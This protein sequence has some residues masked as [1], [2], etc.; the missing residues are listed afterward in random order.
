[1][2]RKQATISVQEEFAGKSLPPGLEDSLP[3]DLQDMFDNVRSGVRRSA[4]AYINLCNILERLAKRNEGIAV[5][6]ARFSSM[7]QTLTEASADPSSK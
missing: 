6:Y 3:S 4:E 2:W 5:E 7:L 1:V